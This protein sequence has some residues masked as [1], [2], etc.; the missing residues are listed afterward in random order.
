MA[1]DPFYLPNAKLPVRIARLGAL[2]FEFVRP[3]DGAPMS[4]ELRFH[5]SRTPE[6]PNSSYV[7]GCL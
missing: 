2:L 3:S 1:D 6:R 7:V 4:C 5:A